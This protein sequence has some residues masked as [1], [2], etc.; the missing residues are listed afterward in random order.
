VRISATQS[1]RLLLVITVFVITAPIFAQGR[2]TANTYHV[3]TTGDLT[4]TLPIPEHTPRIIFRDADFKWQSL[5]VQM[6][7]GKM[8]LYL[9]VTRLGNGRTILGINVPEHVNLEDREPPQVLR[10]IVDD[11]DYGPV[12]NVSLG[13]VEASPR[14]LSIEVADQMNWLRSGTLRV[15][16]NGRSYRLRDSGIEFERFGPK[17][18][19]I[20]VALDELITETRDNNSVQVSIDD[21]G[22]TDKPLQCTLSFAFPL[23]YQMDD[24]TLLSVDTVTSDAG[25]ERWWVVVDGKAMDAGATST[26]GKTWMSESSE[27]PHWIKMTFPQARTVNGIKLW[28][29]YFEAF[30]TSSAYEIQS[31]DGERWVT[32][33]KVDGQS[34]RQCSEHTFAPVSTTAVRVWQPPMSGH[35]ERA[36]LMWLAEFEVF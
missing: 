20:S 15:T 33:V 12:R 16:I 21:Y 1:V 13:G 26:A 7:D 10:F 8:Q 6:A 2:S 36:P 19:V 34:D 23:Q 9:D 5:E 24:G 14:R 3:Q 27:Q 28:W 25:W 31:W 11:K 32:Q 30:R 17:R 35:P 29:A 22:L 4:L 18:G